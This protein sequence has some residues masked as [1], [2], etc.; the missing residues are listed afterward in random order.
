[1]I[2]L[3]CFFLM[4]MLVSFSEIA[5]QGA[6]IGLS[7]WYQNVLPTLLPFMLITGI[8]TRKSPPRKN[9]LI[10]TIIMGI[11]CGYPLGAKICSDF[12]C[13][14]RMNEKKA[15]RLLALCNN[16][17]PMFIS[18]YISHIILKDKYSTLFIFFTIYLPYVVLYVFEEI[19]NKY[20]INLKFKNKS[21][22][23][24]KT[25]NSDNDKDLIIT[26]IT[27]I[28]CICVYIMLCSVVIEFIMIPDFIPQNIKELLAGITETTRGTNIISSSICYYPKIKE[29]LIIALCSFGGISSILQTKMVIAPSGLSIIKYILRKV[30]CSACTYVIVLFI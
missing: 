26:A 9:A 1:M 10:Y 15:N 14:E 5:I 7:L 30:L 25:K 6:E 24:K 4:G 11:F 19:I 18:G 12:V 20:F 27:Q 21:S 17:S 2:T 28:T 13:M 23:D 16:F 3:L 8:L 22:K 29:A